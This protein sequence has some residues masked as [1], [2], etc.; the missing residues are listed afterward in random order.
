MTNARLPQKVR[1]KNGHNR[2]DP[3]FV[4]LLN[5]VLIQRMRIFPDYVAGIQQKSEKKKAC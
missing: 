5:P 3:S 1:D 4:K 2:Y